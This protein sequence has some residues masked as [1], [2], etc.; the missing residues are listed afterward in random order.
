M[1]TRDEKNNFSVMIEEAAIKQGISH[2]DAIV[3]YCEQ[4][5][6]EVEVAATLINVPLKSKIESEARGLRY[7]AKSSELPL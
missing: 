3:S 5:G 4:T 6:L 7:L 2:M 1:P